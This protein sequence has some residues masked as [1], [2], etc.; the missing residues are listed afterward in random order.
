MN[1]GAALTDKVNITDSNFK[2]SERTK[3]FENAEN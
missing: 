1:V 2:N 3:N